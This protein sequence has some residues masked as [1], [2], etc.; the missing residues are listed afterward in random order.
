MNQKDQDGN[1]FSSIRYLILLNAVLAI[2][3][4]ASVGFNFKLY[5][6][7]TISIP[8]DL[9]A[10][11]LIKPEKKYPEDVFS[12]A[13]SVFQSLN[14][15]RTNGEEDYPDNIETLSP[16]LTPNF[17]QLIKSDLE[18]RESKGEL[19]LR[20][21]RLSLPPEYV[22]D[23]NTVRVVNANEWVVKIPL[24]VEE[25]VDDAPV[26]S[27]EVLYSIT[28]KRARTDIQKNA[29]QIALDDFYETPIR[30]K[31]YLSDTVEKH[32]VQKLLEDI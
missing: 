26:K 24:Q 3:L 12:F 13:T 31:D 21:R 27:I 15:W 16:F 29:F 32:D 11:A 9:R 1:L 7:I 5:Q 14:N 8:P 10:G 22:F 2:G 19:E 20:T 25:Y 23:E 17:V 4:I 28:V 30:T 6:E 18:R